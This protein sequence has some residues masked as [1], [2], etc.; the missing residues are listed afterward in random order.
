MTMAEPRPHVVFV[1]QFHGTVG[2]Q[3]YFGQ[4]TRC[5]RCVL[6]K[7]YDGVVRILSRCQRS[8]GCSIMAGWVPSV[9]GHVTGKL[10][11]TTA[12]ADKGCV[13][14]YPEWPKWCSFLFLL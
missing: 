12:A 9:H 10:N 8:G 2:I 7:R 14:A 4:S 5:L 11:S 13:S 3:G 6:P 1:L